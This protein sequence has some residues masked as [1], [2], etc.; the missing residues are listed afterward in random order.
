VA[1]G[2]NPNIVLPD[3][4]F[5]YTHEQVHEM[6]KCANDP[7][8]FIKNY[9]KVVHP[10]R[11]IVPLE[12]YGYQEDMIRLM[13][14]DSDVIV[15][16]AR[17][18]GK[19]TV[20]C[21]YIL[22]FISFNEHKHVHIVSNKNSGAMEMISRIQFMYEN[23]PNWLKPGIDISNW[24][25][26]AL[27]FSN[28]CVIES[29]ATTEQSGRGKSIALLF[30][31]EFAF[32]NPT[33]AE[34]FWASISPTLATGGRMIIASTP[35]GDANLFASLWRGAEVDSNGFKPIFVPWDAPP[36]RDETFKQKQIAKIGPLKWEQEYL[37]KFVSSD[38]LLIDSIFLTEYKRDTVKEQQPPADAR[39]CI[40]FLPF[41]QNT[42]YII[43]ID[44]ATGSGSD[45]SVI[46]VYTYPSL[47]QVLQFRSNTTSSPLLY[48]T[49]KYIL[50]AMERARVGTVYMSVE[51]NGV[52]EGILTAYQLDENIPDV[53]L[54][55]S[56]PGAKRQGMV[57]TGRSKSKACVNFKQLFENGKLQ[58]A[59]TILMNEL[60]NYI[61]G[62]GSYAARRGSTDDCVAALLIVVRIIELLVQHEDDA[63]DLLY[64]SNQ[65]GINEFGE[66]TIVEPEPMY[67]DNNNGRVGAYAVRG[68]FRDINDI[69]SFDPFMG[70][71]G[72]DS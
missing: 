52:G 66:A 39:G 1:R 14:G 47:Q 26:H 46:Q 34:E 23:A 70:M 60:Q 42:T 22:W 29:E 12:L 30:A 24:N 13:H 7:V 49:L 50:Y 37:C 67:V 19:S 55:M 51:N 68:G 27:G 15:L 28:G 65:F 21:A 11:G 69:N 8:H 16:S 17:Q 31:D 53:G 9:I 25:K 44:P 54:M 32:V 61:R 6:L 40:Q 20:S 41:V 72:Y 57:T 4:Q 3:A 62:G 45:F 35:N 33:I 71:D 63:F 58:I 36:D 43:G 38:P 10:T 5:E 64:G 59:S 48:T 56:E 2:K 18:T